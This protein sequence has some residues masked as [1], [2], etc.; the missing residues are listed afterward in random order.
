M[1][2]IKL[3]C[4]FLFSQNLSAQL[5]L[6][7]DRGSALYKVGENINFRVSSD[8]AGSV[9]YKIF[10]DRFATPLATGTVNIAAGQ[11]LSIPYQSDEPGVV[12]CDVFLNGNKAF[13]AAAVDPFDIAPIGTAPTD[14]DMFWDEQKNQLAQV[15]FDLQISL[16]EQHDNSITYRVNLRNVSGRR[17]YGLLSVPDTPGPH[18]AIITLPPF[19]N[20]PG[21]VTP[22]YILA[23]R[24][25]ALS[26]SLSV[27]N[28]PVDQ[29]DPVG[30]DLDQSDDPNE[31]YYRYAILGAIRAI[32]YLETRDDFSGEVAVNGVSQG[33]GLSMLLSGI[34]DR[35]TLMAQSNGAL[36]QHLG[37]LENKASGFPY[38][39][40]QSRA[41]ENDPVHEAQTIEAVK[42]YDAVYLNKN[43]D[44]PTY[45]IISYQ[46]TI[47][48]SATVFAAYN[49]IIAPKVLLHATLLGHQH[50]DEYFS[51]R[52]HFYRRYFSTPLDP[53]WPFM[54]DFTGY[55]VNAGP[56][57]NTNLSN[58]ISLNALVMLN[59]SVRNDLPA[60]WDK[61]SGP[62]NVNFASQ[63]NYQTSASFS[64]PGEY[65]LRF[66]AFDNYPSETNKFY[67]VQDYVRVTVDGTLATENISDTEMIGLRLTPNPATDRVLVNLEIPFF[68]TLHIYNTTGQLVRHADRKHWTNGTEIDGTDLPSGIYWLSFELENEIIVQ[69][70]VVL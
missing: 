16:F 10:Y 21:I 55:L 31:I 59:T 61:I 17:V 7:T 3:L 14:L 64:L 60:N 6:V 18:P 25:G 12:L 4:L 54:E 23:E 2:Y 47:T 56:D 28:T 68:G 70:L 45:H 5:D 29:S 38:Y 9:G 30:Y 43:I 40:G 39:I 33:A 62:G 41:E 51:L 1:K 46:D 69:K 15:P 22:E 20:S 32:D 26:F 36:C 57:V 13:A 65:L 34:D 8:Q 67:S 48:P 35:I 63:N 50:P 53:S 52:R 42:Y 37:I 24:V 58:E 27:H 19:G 49:Q 44:Y 66:T 11:T